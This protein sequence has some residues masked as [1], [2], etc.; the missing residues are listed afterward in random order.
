MFTKYV[1]GKRAENTPEWNIF[2]SEKHLRN[3]LH[4]QF[5]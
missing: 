4:L 1:L 2:K 3:K 5:D